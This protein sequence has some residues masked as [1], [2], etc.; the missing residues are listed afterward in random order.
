MGN[1]QNLKLLFLMY[2]DCS[3][4]STFRSENTGAG[5]RTTG[6]DPFSD[7]SGSLGIREIEKHRHR[8]TQN[9]S[10]IDAEKQG[11]PGET[12]LAEGLAYRPW[13]TDVA[14]R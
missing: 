14:V 8:E 12:C 5:E 3:E 6:L 11:W 9:H 1:S 2:T 13:S 10:N 4:D 7:F